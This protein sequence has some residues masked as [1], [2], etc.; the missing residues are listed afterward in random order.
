MNEL[1]IA[2]VGC[3]FWANDMHIPAFQRLLGARV[4]GVASRSEA[5]A[6]RTAERFGVPRWTTDYRELLDDPKVSVVD[7][8]TPNNLHA[9]IAIAAAENGKHILCIKPMALN[10]HEA[11]CM[12]DAAAKAGV[13]LIYAENVPFIPALT[14]AK[15]IVAEG[16]LGKVFRVKACEGIGMPHGPWFFDHAQTGGGA[17]IDMAVHSIAF[18]RWIAGAEADTVYAEAGTFVHEMKDEDTAVLT[19]RFKNGIIGQTEDSWSLAAAMDS[20]F[21]IF[22]TK[23]R[24]LVD[25]LHRQP[26]QVVSEEGYSYWGGPK[27]GGKGWT[28]PLPLPGDIVDG[29]LAMLQHFVDCLRTGRPTR[30][31]AADGRE[32]VGHERCERVAIELRDADRRLAA[33]NSEHLTAT[34]AERSLVRG[35]TCARRFGEYAARRAP[36]V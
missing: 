34:L 26:M 35:L 12:I 19:L 13:Q 27:E 17:I 4:V 9:P 36:F 16:A 8:L 6:R 20:R 23:G 11:D 24:I 1:G 18:C 2:V 25:N 5:S 29:Q 7:I 15:E 22:G 33:Q 31:T 10:L 32:S 14:R 30:S 3:G 21:E 28:Y